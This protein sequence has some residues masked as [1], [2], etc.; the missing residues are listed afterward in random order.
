MVKIKPT[1]RSGYDNVGDLETVFA[2]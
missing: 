2:I 1:S